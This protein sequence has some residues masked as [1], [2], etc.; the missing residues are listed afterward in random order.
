V[1]E[2][3]PHSDG[4]VLQSTMR[5]TSATKEKFRRAIQ[6]SSLHLRSQFPK[7]VTPDTRGV[8]PT[9]CRHRRGGMSALPRRRPQF[10]SLVAVANVGVLQDEIHKPME[11]K[12][13]R[14]QGIYQ[15]TRSVEIWRRSG[16]E[17][18]IARSTLRRGTRLFLL[19]RT[20]RAGKRLN[21]MAYMSVCV[22]QPE[23]GRTWWAAQDEKEIRTGRAV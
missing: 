3:L 9:T 20:D 16:A 18:Q 19:R 5:R 17:L 2:V 11:I 12:G 22:A 23:V 10:S 21:N 4:S 14:R 13:G 6:R 8:A 1:G 7:V 15:S